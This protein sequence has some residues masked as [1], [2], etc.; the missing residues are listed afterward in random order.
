M[1]NLRRSSFLHCT[2]SAGALAI[3][4]VAATPASAANECGIPSG[5]VV[6]CDQSD[7]PFDQGIDYAVDGDL[8]VSG[9][10]NYVGK[11]TLG[12]GP[13]LGREQGDFFD[14]GLEAKLGGPR[15]F[16]FLRATNLTDSVGNR[17][18]LGSVFSVVF[19]DQITPL[20]PRTLRLGVHASF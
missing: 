9:W 1:S 6:Q 11:S 3:A 15:R 16:V 2:V 14:A 19:E 20:R 17:F 13:I 7:A 18:A 5:G 8:T 12:I 10:A 4:V